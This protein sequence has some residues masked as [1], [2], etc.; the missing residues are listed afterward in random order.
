MIATEDDRDGYAPGY[1]VG[2]YQLEMRLGR[3]GMGTVWLATRH[4][5]AFQKNVAIKLVKRG[6]DS[7][8]ILRRFRTERQVLANLDH[9][10]IAR[11]IDGGSTP[12]GLP[13]LVMEYVEGVPL[14]RFC[15]EQNCS[16]EE[17]LRLFRS[18]CAAVHYAHQNLVVH[19]DIKP[20]N[21]LVTRDGV[22]K[23]LDF[24]IAK[25]LDPDISIRD[26]AQTRPGMPPMTLDYA[27]PEQVRGHDVDARTDLYL[28]GCVAYELLTGEPPFL[29]ANALD[30]CHHQ[31][32]TPPP[33]LTDRLKE[34]S[35]VKARG[36]RMKRERELPVGAFAE[37]LHEAAM[38]GGAGADLMAGGAVNDT[39]VVDD[40]ADGRRGQ[41]LLRVGRSCC[42]TRRRRWALRAATTRCR[43]CHPRRSHH[44]RG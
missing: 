30:L 15:E 10:N 3:G 31:L 16:I 4:D 11:L 8:E 5:E 6:M 38:D 17:R 33:P 2:S 35:A 1:R 42:G 7:G 29:G 27:S 36:G 13:Y 37:T 19:R 26:K 24:G 41:G 40:A 39:Y 18:V 12:D 21:I 43:A 32:L 20:G 23:L 44:S 34:R 28:V 14:D 25:L 9:P 22:P